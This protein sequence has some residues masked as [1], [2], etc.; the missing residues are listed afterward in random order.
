MILNYKKIEKNNLIEATKIQRQ[1]FPHNSAYYDYLKDFNN[2]E[3]L[4]EH[5]I[6]YDENE[7]IGIT[8]V[9]MEGACNEVEDIWLGWYGVLPNKRRKGY[10][11]Q[12]LMDTLNKANEFSNKYSNLLYFRLYTSYTLF[13]EAQFL[14]TKVM[15]EK[16]KYTNKSDYTY[17]NSVLIYSKKLKNIEIKSWNNRFL[18]LKQSYEDE[19]RANQINF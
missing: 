4:R 2:V 6:V 3:N 16:E 12:I 7:I 15:D 5:Y 18:N 8:G 19:Q 9:Y 13:P 11:K 14:Y 10:G 1:I 17:D